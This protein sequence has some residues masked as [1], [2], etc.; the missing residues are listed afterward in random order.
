[1]E[2]CQASDGEHDI[3]D[4]HVSRQSLQN[5]PPVLTVLMRA[6]G[7]Q[8][9]RD[10]WNTKRNYHTTSKTERYECI[11]RGTLRIYMS[12][13][14]CIYMCIYLCGIGAYIRPSWTEYTRRRV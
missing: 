13:S 4:Q 12:I 10:R 7:R 3:R 9:N 11:L 14:L 6:S 1:M 5:E 8:K 2:D